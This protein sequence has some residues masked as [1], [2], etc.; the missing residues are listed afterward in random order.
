M[1]SWAAALPPAPCPREAVEAE[2]LPT[3]G[4]LIRSR[5]R[6]LAAPTAGPWCQLGP[7]LPDGLSSEDPDVQVGPGAGSVRVPLSPS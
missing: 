6:K 1:A 5:E 4:C 3:C 2:P 7:A